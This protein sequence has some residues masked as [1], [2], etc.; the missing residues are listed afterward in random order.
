[1]TRLMRIETQKKLLT[2]LK[3]KSCQGE[4]CLL[5]SGVSGFALFM[6][7]AGSWIFDFQSFLIYGLMGFLMAG[8]LSLPF[9]A[10]GIWLLER[11]PD[12]ASRKLKFLETGM[13]LV[14]AFWIMAAAFCMFG[15][16]SQAQSF[17][18]EVGSQHTS[19]GTR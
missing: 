4:L 5:I 11:S 8:L 2:V 1:M 17:H 19:T 18:L 10:F 14:A 16:G 15:A 9:G 6:S 3:D 13:C 12:D 7:C